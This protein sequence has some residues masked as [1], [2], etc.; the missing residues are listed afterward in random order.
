MNC[1]IVDDN[2]VALSLVRQ[3]ISKVDDLNVIAECNNAIEAYNFL[4]NNKVDVIFLDI[5]MPEM[6]GIELTKNLGQDHPIIVFTTSK[7]EYAVEAFELNIAD[8]LIKPISI[9]RFLQAIEKVKTIYE[10]KHEDVKINDE[11]FLFIRDSNV[12][13][14]IKTEDILYVEAMGD[15]VKIHIPN[16]LYAIHSTLKAVESRLSS[17]RFMR[18]H[19]SYIVAIPNIDSLEDGM[20]IINKKAIPVADA[21][22][23]ALNKRLNVI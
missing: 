2:R 17:T 9:P 10:S 19:R 4:Q 16:K 15:Y 6:T 21:F 22:R 23:S 8:Y 5:E 13:R 18:V 14:R 11:E 20:I 1:I 12:I 3:L 7:E